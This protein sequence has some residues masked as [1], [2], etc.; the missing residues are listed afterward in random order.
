[1]PKGVKKTPK[2]PGFMRTIVAENLKRLMVKHYAA[3]ENKHKKLAKDAGVSL[4]T[5]QR[6]VKCE[7]GASLD[8]IEALAGAFD[9]SAYQLL[10]PELDTSNPQVVQGASESEKR[11]YRRWTHAQRGALE[12]QKV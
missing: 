5:V 11:A 1:M 8:N 6:I 10:I 4:S 12:T 3:I 7:T 9:L 2:I